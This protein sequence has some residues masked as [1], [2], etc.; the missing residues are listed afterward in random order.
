M[1]LTPDEE[2]IYIPKGF[3]GIINYEV[4]RNHPKNSISNI[5]K[6][7]SA[8]RNINTKSV[9]LKKT[10]ITWHQQTSIIIEDIVPSYGSNLKTILEIL[11]SKNS[12]QSIE[13][14]LKMYGS[15]LLQSSLGESNHGAST[16]KGVSKIPLYL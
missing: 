4:F 6:N 3:W 5:V 14:K 10:D 7:I 1:I 2:L 15:C 16:I 12:I 8:I 13:I 11:D 9:Y